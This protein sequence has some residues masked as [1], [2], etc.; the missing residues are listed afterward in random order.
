MEECGIKAIRVKGPKNTSSL[1]RIWPISRQKFETN[2]FS[3]KMEAIYST[4]TSVNKTS[5]RRH[6]PEDDIILK[7]EGI[8]SSETS[9]HTRSTRRHIPEDSILTLK[10]EGFTQD[11]HGVTS[12]KTAFFVV[13]A[14]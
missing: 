10:M 5:T 14:V 6:I 11:L 3:L 7:M 8:R 13:T 2:I 9:V 4:E 1:K 12:Q